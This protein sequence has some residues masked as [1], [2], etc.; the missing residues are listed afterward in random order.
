MSGSDDKTVRLWDAMTGVALL[1]LEGHSGSVSS[2]TFSLDAF[3]LD[4]KVEQALFV[5]NDW[6]GEGKGKFL[7]LPPN[8]RAT[9]MAVWNRVIVLGH[10]SGT[11]SILG[12]KEGS[13]LI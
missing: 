9:S 12:F 4:G 1:T 7:W 8:Y 3:S 6:V 2:V 11:I 5:S 10:S 13:K